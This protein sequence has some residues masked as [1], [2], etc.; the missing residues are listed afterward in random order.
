M[1]FRIFGWPLRGRIE[2]RIARIARMSCFAGACAAGWSGVSQTRVQGA[3]FRGQEIVN[4]VA[5]CYRTR[6]IKRVD[7]C[8][9]SLSVLSGFFALTLC[10]LHFVSYTL[11][12]RF[13][14]YTS[15]PHFVLTLCRKLKMERLVVSQTIL[16]RHRPR[17]RV[18]GLPILPELPGLPAG[19]ASVCLP[20][21]L[22]TSRRSS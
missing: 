6:K 12:P 11:S 21:H 14:G 2:L 13:V 5:S 16:F 18:P 4:F 7:A 8:R 3:G 15:S 20:A 9:L 19:G 17:H 22:R 10:L 1:I